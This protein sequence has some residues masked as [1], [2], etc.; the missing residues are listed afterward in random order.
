MGRGSPMR[1]PPKFVHGFTDRHG[2][3]RFY[4]RRPGFKSIPLPG[5]PWS[6]EFMAS[7]EAALADQPIADWRFAHQRRHHQRGPCELLQQSIIPHAR[8]RHTTFATIDTR[9][10]PNRAQREAYIP[11][12]APAHRE[13]A[14][15]KAAVR[16]AELAHCLARSNEARG[17][18]WHDR[19]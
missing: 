19:G 10:L 16:R 14:R 15:P 3:A 17:R 9:T 13:A 6:P 1:R 12:S 8:T 4:L 18:D 2:R 5:L 7:Y 11:A